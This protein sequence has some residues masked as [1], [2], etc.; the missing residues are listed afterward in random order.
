MIRA[1]ESREGDEAISW[2]SHTIRM[3]DTHMKFLSCEKLSSLP[4]IAVEEL[5][6]MRRAYE[7]M[8][9]QRKFLMPEVENTIEA[10]PH[11]A[12][13]VLPCVITTSSPCKGPSCSQVLSFHPSKSFV[14]SQFAI[15]HKGTHSRRSNLLPTGKERMA[16]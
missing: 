12:L 7:A 11:L 15:A 4:R 5:S 8:E 9:S 10:I 2:R 16:T 14:S 6:L 13:I 3:N 1:G